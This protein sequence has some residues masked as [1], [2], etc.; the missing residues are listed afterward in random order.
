VQ[1]IA[2]PRIWK[3]RWSWSA[4][5]LNSR[6]SCRN[7]LKKT[8]DANGDAADRAVAP[9]AVEASR[10]QRRHRAHQAILHAVLRTAWIRRRRIVTRER[11]GLDAQHTVRANERTV[12]IRCLARVRWARWCG[13][14]IDD[15]AAA[16]DIAADTLRA[17]QAQWD[18][19]RLRL[20]PRGAPVLTATPAQRAELTHFLALHGAGV[21]V[22]VLQDHFPGLPRREL[23]CFLF[24][25]RAR[26]L[27]EAQARHYAAV[28]WQRPGAVWAID[29]TEPPT[30]IDGAF[31]W[32]LTVRDLASGA[33]L[34][35]QPVAHADADST[36]ACLR[37]L[38][39]RHG[40]PLVIKADN[41][42]A[43][44]AAAFRNDLANRGI[45]LLF[46]PPYCPQYNGACEAGNGTIKTL[47]HLIAARHDRPDVWTLDDLEAA[48]CW[49][50]RRC[51]AR[52]QTLTPE[53]RFAQRVAM[54]EQERAHFHVAVAA[55]EQRRR[56]ELDIASPTS[57]RSI[58]ADALRR[59]A[60]AD[61]LSG[62]GFFTIR[63]RPV[64]LC[65]PLREVG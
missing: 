50:N 11:G 25:E 37:D 45:A 58:T 21:G 65:N 18:A 55:A 56:A 31:P 39:A 59:H 30:A 1:R 33:T 4:A 26:G 20:R 41:G 9:V 38:I 19:G 23:A 60:I 42:P 5:A 52:T 64:R 2:A 57:Q 32:V 8:A 48:R 36:I 28:I 44:I 15:V 22:S 7:G 16:L 51:T 13:W 53:Q 62:L 14:R 43:F 6:S 61:A 54:S 35:A 27:A 12:R 46:S 29:H 10:H 49:A 34:A 40:A 24:G 63:S 17:W 47:T 3:S